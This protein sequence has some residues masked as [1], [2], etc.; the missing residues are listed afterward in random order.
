MAN[1]YHQRMIE[2]RKKNN[3]CRDCGKPLDRVGAR[4]IEC[5]NKKNAYQNET[6]RYYQ[7]LGFCP[8]CKIGKLYGDE[9]M[10]IECSRRIQE[11]VLKS[12]DRLEYNK[13][14]AEWSRRTHKQMVEQ[15]ICYRCRKRKSDLGYTTCG[16]C[17]TKL[18][19]YKREI[20]YKC[21]KIEQGICYYCDK[22]VKQ[23]YKVC[24]EHYNVCTNNSRS[25]KAIQ[26]RREISRKYYTNYVKGKEG[27]NVRTD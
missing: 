26:A 19:E 25:E 7:S 1:I 8:R 2:K 15:G 20:N 18:R 21:R 5:N 16:I 11:N 22:P 10:C 23:G 9:K 24:E 14:H 12:R 17:R 3:L 27:K 4:C 13:K 6:R